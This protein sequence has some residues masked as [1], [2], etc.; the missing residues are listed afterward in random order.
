MQGIHT[1]HTSE[2]RSLKANLERKEGFTCAAIGKHF[3]D[4]D[5]IY[6]DAP[7]EMGIEFL[8]DLRNMDEWAHLLKP[9]GEISASEG[10]FRDEYNQKVKA[11]VQLHRLSKYLFARTRILLSRTRIL[12]AHSHAFN[13]GFL[14]ICRS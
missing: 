6:V 5:T 13:T 8:Q 11:S 14:C 7:I 1:V 4:T 9:D 2:C 12:S 3:V 10:E